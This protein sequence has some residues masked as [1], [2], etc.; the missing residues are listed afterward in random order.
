M[1]FLAALSM[2]FPFVVG[3][4]R[5]RWPAAD[6]LLWECAPARQWVLLGLREKPQM[7]SLPNGDRA[8]LELRKIA[9]YCLNPFH[10]RG[11]H[12]ARVFRTA[13]GIERRDAAWLRE[14]FLD[15][16]RDKDAVALEGDALGTRWRIDVSVSR[17][18]RQIVVRT[19][20]IVRTGED[21]PRFVTCWVL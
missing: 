14:T 17:Q 18:N 2:T 11:R 8:V 6:V 10:P 12:K 1:S 13:L 5:W 19:V 9:D 16:A 15:A 7:A 4:S 20:W 21:F 3:V